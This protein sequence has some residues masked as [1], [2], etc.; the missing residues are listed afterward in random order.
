ME[1]LVLAAL[2]ASLGAI[3]TASAQPDQ[4]YTIPEFTFE[5]GESLQNMKVGYSTHGTLNADRSNAVLITHGTS[6]NRNVYNLFIGPGKALDT[7]RT[8]SSPS[9]RSAAGSRASRRIA[10]A[11]ISR[12]TRCAT[13]SAPSMSW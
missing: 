13:W 11:R 12:N 3:G 4:V 2:V 1:R 10:W 9:M 7:D 8:S 5:N 6:Q